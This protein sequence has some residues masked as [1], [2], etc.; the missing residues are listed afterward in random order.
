MFTM[1]VVYIVLMGKSIFWIAPE[2]LCMKEGCCV[3][4]GDYTHN[5]ELEVNHADGDAA[6][7]HLR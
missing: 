7:A 2:N 4:L 3:A 5:Y 1:I 6:H